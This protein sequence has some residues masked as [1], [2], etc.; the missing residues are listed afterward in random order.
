MVASAFSLIVAQ[1]LARRN[2]KSCLTEDVK[3][4]KESLLQFGFTEEE[5]NTFKPMK[6]PGCAECN[7]SGYK[8][9]QGIYEVLKKSPSLEAGILKDARADELLAAAV[10]DGF[11]TMQVIGRG[12]IKSGVLSV[13]EYSRILVV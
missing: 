7:S 12:F 9:R 1:R 13:A 10:K 11:K 5:L 4:T 2:C 6:S 8:G 3:A